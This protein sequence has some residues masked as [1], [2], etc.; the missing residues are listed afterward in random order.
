M[1]SRGQYQQKKNIPLP[2]HPN[3]NNFIQPST[4]PSIMSTRPT[5]KAVDSRPSTDTLNSTTRHRT[6]KQVKKDTDTQKAD[7]VAALQ[8]NEMEK[9]IKQGHIANIEDNLWKEDVLYENK[10]V[11]PDLQVQNHKSS[12]LTK[13]REPEVADPEDTQADGLGFSY[14]QYT[15]SEM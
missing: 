6:S 10:S 8:S 12:N 3:F 4:P 9:H 7:A 15:D 11:C 13:W 2:F 14:C 1:A 5:C